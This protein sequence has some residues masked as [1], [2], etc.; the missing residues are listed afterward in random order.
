[1]RNVFATIPFCRVNFSRDVFLRHI[2]PVRRFAA[3]GF[4]TRVPTGLLAKRRFGRR[5]PTCRFAVLY[6]SYDTRVL[7]NETANSGR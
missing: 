1:M 5:V 6:K 2:S 3:Q 4:S 7:R